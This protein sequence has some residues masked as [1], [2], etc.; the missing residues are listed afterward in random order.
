MSDM[1]K[2]LLININ[3]NHRMTITN[4]DDLHKKVVHFINKFYPDAIVISGCIN[5]STD[6]LRLQSYSKGYVAGQP[7]LMIVNCHPSYG[8]LAI[9]FKSPSGIGKLSLKQLECLGKLRDN[10]WLCLVSNCYDEIIMRLVQYF[11]EMNLDEGIDIGTSDMDT[12]IDN[13]SDCELIK[14]NTKKFK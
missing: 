8:G 7:D 5:Q 10:M 2:P 14:P 4:K 9:E 3:D 11:D 12:E 13:D 6:K 1:S